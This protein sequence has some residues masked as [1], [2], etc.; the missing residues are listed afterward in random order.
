MA[1]AYKHPHAEATYR[2]FPVKEG[3]YAVEVAIPENSPT[4]VTSFS[5]E[6]VAQQWIAEHQR[7][8]ASGNRLLRRIWPAK[9]AE[10]R[11]L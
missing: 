10:S 5:T 4:R 3:A 7:Q 2:I 9:P 8:A 6:E 1:T 11:R